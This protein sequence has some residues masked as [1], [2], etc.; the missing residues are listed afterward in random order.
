MQAP[1]GTAKGAA[2]TEAAFDETGVKRD[3]RG[4]AAALVAAAAI[5]FSA[6][7]LVIAGFSPLSSQ[8]TRSVHVGFLLLLAYLIYP[9]SK[10]ADRRRIA[11]YDAALAALAFALAFYHWVFEVELIQRAGEPIVADLVVGTVVVLLVFEAARRVLADNV[12]LGRIA[13]S[14]VV[15]AGVF[16]AGLFEMLVQSFA[17]VA[18][19]LRTEMVI[20]SA[21]TAGLGSMFWFVLKLWLPSARPM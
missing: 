1:E 3:L 8:V 17:A 19:C 6:Y 21:A 11:W 10:R 15:F 5:S 14:V 13:G 12:S 9:V 4:T 7:Q 18:P 16:A 20:A 2:T